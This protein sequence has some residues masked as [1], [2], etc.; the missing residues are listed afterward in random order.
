[1]SFKIFLQNTINSNKL[2]ID[3][4]EYPKAI[5]E[6]DQI[7]LLEFVKQNL[8]I[9]YVIFKPEHYQCSSKLKI[10]IFSRK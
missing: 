3:L 4:N 7:D 2:I 10:E 5:T 1:M 9:G 8:H 6:N